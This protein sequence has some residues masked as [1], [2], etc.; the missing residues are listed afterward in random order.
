VWQR[1][2]VRKLHDE[3][4]RVALRKLVILDAAEI[5]GDLRVP[6]GHRGRTGSDQRV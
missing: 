1:E 5:I 4:Q 2:V 6:P 3:L